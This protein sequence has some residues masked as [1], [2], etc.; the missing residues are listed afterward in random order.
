MSAPTAQTAG[1]SRWWI[2]VVVAIAVLL[3]AV[4]LVGP[5]AQPPSGPPLDPGSSAPDGLLGLV[6]T[7]EALDVEVQLTSA[8]PEDT[9]TRA[10]LPVD[11]LT[12]EQREAWSSWIESGGTLILPDRWSD[13]HDREVRRPGFADGRVREQRRAGCR[14]M[15]DEIGMVVHDSWGELPHEPDEVACFGDEGDAG[16][17][18]WLVATTVGEG[19]IIL[20]GSA[21]PFTNGWLAEGDNAVLAAALFAPGDA[22]RMVLIPRDPSA[23]VDAGLLDLVPDGVWRLLLLLLLAVIVGIIARARRLGQPVE[24]RL[25]PVLPSAELA[26]SVAG[27]TRRAGDREGAAR[28]LRDRAR[29]AVARSFG[30]PQHTDPA[31]LLRRFLVASAWERSDVAPAFLDTPVASDDDLLA[32][33]QAVS[34]VLRELS[35]SATVDHA[36]PTSTTPETAPSH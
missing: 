4:L 3:L 12:E 30:M 10:L 25:P 32:V 11:L 26:T 16:D 21:A 27:L 33:S 23:E 9:D 29:T 35:G 15:P 18:G 28:M 13:L 36:T 31:D 20:L 19:R 6:R 14:E 7:L 24:E 8:P 5:A 34:R 22:D 17:G 2:P 1:P